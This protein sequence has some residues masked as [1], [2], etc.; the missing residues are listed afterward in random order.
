MAFDADAYVSIHQI[1]AVVASYI[2][3]SIYDSCVLHLVDWFFIY[4]AAA[5][6]NAMDHPPSETFSSDQ[7]L[8]GSLVTSGMCLSKSATALQQCNFTDSVPNRVPTDVESQGINLV[9][10]KSGKM[11]CITQVAAK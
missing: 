1:S 6:V 9:R 8:Y 4:T 3:S 10:E 5:V 11:M 7:D 2:E